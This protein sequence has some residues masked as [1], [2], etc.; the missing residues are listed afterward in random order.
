MRFAQGF[1]GG[2]RGIFSLLRGRKQEDFGDSA[3]GG[4]QK[5]FVVQSLAKQ[6]SRAAR[7]K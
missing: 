4:R 2:R 3:Q 1:D 6:P 5:T 7:A